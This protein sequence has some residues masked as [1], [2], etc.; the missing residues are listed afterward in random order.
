[1]YLVCS[2]SP[3]CSLWETVCLFLG[4]HYLDLGL[5]RD[6]H[7]PVLTSLPRRLHHLVLILKTKIQRHQQMMQTMLIGGALSLR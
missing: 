7:H 4:E 1:M 2:A 6:H 5:H 3:F